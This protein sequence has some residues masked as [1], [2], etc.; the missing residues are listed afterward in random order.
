[1]TECILLKHKGQVA[2]YNAN[3]YNI[4]SKLYSTLE[5][6]K[7]NAQQCMLLILPLVRLDTGRPWTADIGQLRTQTRTAF[8]CM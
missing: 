6:I 1:M 4:K 8:R 7:Q 2:T 5:K 3:V